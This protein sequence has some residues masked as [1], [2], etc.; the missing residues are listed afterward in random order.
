MLG[1]GVADLLTNVTDRHPQVVAQ[2]E[3]FKFPY[4]AGRGAV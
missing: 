1:V 3:D 4:M 2:F